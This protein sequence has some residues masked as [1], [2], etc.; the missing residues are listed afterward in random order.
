MADDDKK[1]EDPKALVSASASDL[2]G[3]GKTATTLIGAIERGIGAAAL[4]WHIRRV[5]AAEQ[6]AARGWMVVAREAGL[7]PSTTE[8]SIQERTVM[9]VIAE[10]SRFQQNREA[11]AVAAIEDRR[12]S[13]QQASAPVEPEPEWLDRFWRLA[14]E[15]S[16]PYM[17]MLWG[18]VLSRQTSGHGAFSPRTL[19]ML[20]TLTPDEAH[21]LKRLAAFTVQIEDGEPHAILSFN[22]EK[23]GEEKELN[24]L[25]THA[26]A[27]IDEDAFASIGIL[28]P[29]GI[30][31]SVRIPLAQQTNVTLGGCPYLLTPD[32]S[33]SGVAGLV[34][35]A[36]GYPYS[37]N[38]REI[39]RLI[40]V[41]PDPTFIA[42]VARALSP[43]G[44]SLQ[45]NA[46]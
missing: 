21:E 34:D 8:L 35:F 36:S 22:Q 39:L 30:V 15:A 23:P 28:V 25:L 26:R 41:D 14:Q 46:D 40:E 19:D 31:P 12:D 45:R 5:A 33:V 4:P 16:T 10:Q 43:R 2:L 18:R 29:F 6:E 32:G 1:P 44:L 38:G 24:R 11:V 37:R 27:G 13:A 17:Q 7:E 3:I 9:R 42:T 20:S